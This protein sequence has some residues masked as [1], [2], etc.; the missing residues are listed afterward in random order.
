[1]DK[2]SIDAGDKRELCLTGRKKS[3]EFLMHACAE[4]RKI[5][6]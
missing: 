2:N 5:N 3:N 6:K 1:M 4:K